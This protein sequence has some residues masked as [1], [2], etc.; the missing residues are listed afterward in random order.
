MAKCQKCGKSPQFGNNRPWSRKATRH[1]WKVNIQKVKN[2]GKR[3]AGFPP[4]L[5]LLHP[6]ACE[7]LRSLIVTS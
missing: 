6:H 5:H 7:G 1:K 2:S 3:Q 4:P